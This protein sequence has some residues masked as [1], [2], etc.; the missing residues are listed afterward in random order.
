MDAAKNQY[1]GFQG[2]P[3]QSLG[4]ASQALGS[5]PT[6]ADNNANQKPRSV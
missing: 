5:T 6:P 3:G 4:Y 2:A 1:A